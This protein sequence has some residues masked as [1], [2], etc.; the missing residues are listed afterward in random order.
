MSVSSQ[1]HYNVNA[2]IRLGDPGAGSGRLHLL[3]HLV[4]YALLGAVPVVSS[5]PAPALVPW[6]KV[7]SLATTAEPLVVGCGTSGA[8][9]LVVGCVTNSRAVL[10][11][12]DE[13]REYVALKTFDN[14]H[15]ELSCFVT[16][17]RLIVFLPQKVMPY[18][19]FHVL[20]PRL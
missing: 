5:P 17:L 3:P 4:R 11:F 19:L 15:P 7:R 2:H 14:L 20:L 10:P 12:E 13:R 8:A 18:V 9:P 1:E 6:H 16:K